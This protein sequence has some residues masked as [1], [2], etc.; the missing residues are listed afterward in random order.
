MRTTV[1]ITEQQRAEL[2]RMA[3]ARGEKGFSSVI[4]EAIDL[5]LRQHRSRASAVRTALGVRGALREGEAEQLAAA[6]R[7]QRERWR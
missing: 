7:A 1:E 2:L 3:A 5:Y 4:R 6:V